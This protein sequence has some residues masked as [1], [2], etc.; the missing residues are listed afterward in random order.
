MRTRNALLLLPAVGLL[1][2]T[3]WSAP[4]G[5]HTWDF[6]EVFSNADGTIQFIEL[7]ECCGG[8]GETGLPGHTLSSNSQSW[9][10]PGGP[11]TPPTSNK[12]YLIAT[13]AFAALP[14]APTPDAIIPAGQVP[15]F[16]HMGD[17]LTYAPWDTWNFGAIPNDGINS[18]KRNGTV[19]IN[20]PTNY[21]GATGTVNGAPPVSFYCT[22]KTTSQGCVPFLT[23]SGDPSATSGP[24]SIFSND[25]IEFAPAIYMYSF[26]KG[27]LNFH[28]GKLCV[29]APFGRISSLVKATDQ[30]PCVTCPGMCRMFKRNFND[31]IQSG[32]DPN[33]TAGQQ[34]RIQ[35]RQRDLADPTGFGDNFSDGVAFTIGP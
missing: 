3:A 8:A 15:F 16:N 6:T 5:S 27:S 2:L 23:T 31:F 35:A 26:G 25:H 10:I 9:V 14:G 33:L 28:G 30:L 7:Q 20:D 17:S 32:V 24:F 13:A 1:S 11:L 19:S 21:A 12:H 29:K 22:G 4:R 34:V 18:L